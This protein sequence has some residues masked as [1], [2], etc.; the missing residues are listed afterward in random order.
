[1]PVDRHAHAKLNL[2]LSLGKALP[3]GH[4]HAGYHPICSW[5]H[6]VELHDDLRIDRVA[7]GVQLLVTPASMKTW[8][9]EADLC[10]RA[11]RALEAA[12]DKPLPV[13]IELTKRIPAGGGLGGGS[14][15]AAA[16]LLALRELFALHV[17]DEALRALG[18]RLGSDVPFFLDARDHVP[19]RPA[20]VTGVGETLERTHAL[21]DALLLV[22]PGFACETREVY[23][24]Y[25]AHRDALARERAQILARRGV[26]GRDPI[27]S[28]HEELVRNRTEKMLRAGRIDPDAL[29]NDLAIPAFRVQPRL[30]VLATNLARALRTPVHVTGSGS[31]LVIVPPRSREDATAEK[32]RTVIAGLLDRGEL[33][34]CSPAVVPTR[35]V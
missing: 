35:L 1:M 32:A 25:D 11:V 16:T 21:G 22:L 31:T 28:P 8:P 19:P 30:G 10:V 29:M 3:D 12:I 24:A 6:A 27:D 34:D 14:S 2:L 26:R 5:F 4:A 18:A 33:S 20:V 13:R 15:N 17:D 23:R 7:S 9:D